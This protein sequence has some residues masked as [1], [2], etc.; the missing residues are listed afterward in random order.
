MSNL[1]VCFL[2]KQKTEYEM[3]ISDWSS[4][5]CSSDL[6]TDVE[7]VG[8]LFGQLQAMGNGVLEAGVLAAVGERIGGDIDDAHH[9]RTIELQDA[10]GAIE[11]WRRVEHV[12]PG[13]GV[14]APFCTNGAATPACP[15]KWWSDP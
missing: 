10:A 6:A 15:R 12:S 2:Y 13:T 5:V 4:D 8:A 11:L 14:R 7:D 1:F 9:P 3:R